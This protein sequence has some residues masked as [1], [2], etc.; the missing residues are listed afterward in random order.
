M[1]LVALVYFCKGQHFKKWKLDKE[2][3]HK[4]K[5]KLVKLVSM[6]IFSLSNAVC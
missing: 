1:L 2:I 3:M 4:D 6:G 5:T